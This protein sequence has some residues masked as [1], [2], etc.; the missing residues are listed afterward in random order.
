MR[1]IEQATN[2]GFVLFTINATDS[3]Q[4]DLA[5]SEIVFSLGSTTQP[6]GVNSATGVLIVSASL[7]VQ[8]YSIM[9]IVT[10]KG[11]PTMSSSATFTVEVVPDNNHAPVFQ[12]TP[13]SISISED[14]QGPVPIVI[15]T[16]TD[17]DTTMNEGLVNVS[18]L[19]SNTSSYLEIVID[20]QTVSETRF[21]FSFN[22]ALLDRETLP[23]FTVNLSAVDKA[24]P[25]F[26]R[27]STAVLT[28]TVTDEN[29]ND[30]MFV[31]TPYAADV[32]ENA[33]FGQQVFQVN[34]TDADVGINAQILFSLANGTET[35]DIDSATGWIT[36]KGKLLQAQ[37]SQYILEV[38]AVDENGAAGGRTATTTVTVNVLEVND[39]HPQF[40]EPLNGANFVLLENVTTGTI[41]VNISVFDIDIGDPGNVT[42]SIQPA[43]L[44]FRI[45]GNSLVVSSELNYEVR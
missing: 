35:F 41:V 45:E 30:P 9:V 25:L 36:V 12:N 34:V 27:S 28:V 5:N 23:M 15:F 14:P 10:D 33:T 43:G 26:R 37:T 40:I 2:I 13:L 38:R 3:D 20:S 16:V 18:I 8:T 22:T 32:A 21:Y 17:A 1:V 4:A 31:N 6:F 11:N 29:D 7:S 44:P 19:P 39:N 42:I 24:Y